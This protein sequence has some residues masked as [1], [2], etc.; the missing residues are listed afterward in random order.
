MCNLQ[1]LV[2]CEY[3][4]TRGGYFGTYW[5]YF[6]FL[7]LLIHLTLPMKTGCW[8]FHQLVIATMCLITG[9]VLKCG[10]KWWVP[11]YGEV[12]YL[13]FFIL[14]FILKPYGLQSPAPHAPVPMCLSFISCSVSQ[15]SSEDFKQWGLLTREP[16]GQWLSQNAPDLPSTF[17]SLLHPRSWPAV[18]PHHQASWSSGFWSISQEGTLE[19]WVGERVGGD[20]HSPGFPCTAFSISAFW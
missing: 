3:F 8:I 4:Q 12:K 20:V 11:Y 18:G 7:Q 6:L 9:V 13:I 17:P 15:V 2:E 5:R 1:N 14:Y 19:P 10:L 16:L